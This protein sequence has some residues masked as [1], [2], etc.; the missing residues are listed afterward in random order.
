M[1]LGF[2]R[3][4]AAASA[5]FVAQSPC[6]CCRGRSKD[7]EGIPSA[8][9][10]PSSTA[11]DRAEETSSARESVTAIRLGDEPLYDVE[12]IVGV[13]GLGEIGLDPVGPA[14]VD[15]GL[16]GLGRQEDNRNIPR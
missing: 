6:S 15:V 3:P 1:S 2:P 10:T 9:S 13:E 12:Q 14:F 7:G 4:L 5:M 8:G 16:L 11:L